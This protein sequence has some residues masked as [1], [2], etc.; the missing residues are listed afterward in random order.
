MIV[1]EPV[2]VVEIERPGS[3]HPGVLHHNLMKR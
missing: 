3:A 1:S 2:E